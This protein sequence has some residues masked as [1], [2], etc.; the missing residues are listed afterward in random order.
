MMEE[1][2]KQGLDDFQ[3]KEPGST[4]ERKVHK[5]GEKTFSLKGK[6]YSI[7]AS[8]D[9][10]F[11]VDVAESP[12]GWGDICRNVHRADFYLGYLNISGKED[13]EAYFLSRYD[14]GHPNYKS[15]NLPA[16]ASKA[17]TTTHL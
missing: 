4:L 7:K 16:P 14:E 13:V 10:Y 3:R 5:S 11:V 8:A 12:R 6:E 9:P 2:K 1:L 17:R 15:K